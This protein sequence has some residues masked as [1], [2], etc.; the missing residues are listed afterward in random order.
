MAAQAA[1]LPAVVSV[2]AVAVANCLVVAAA[3]AARVVVAHVAAPLA[4]FESL[5]KAAT[6]SWLFSAGPV[7]RAA[8]Q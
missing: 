8:L 2:L 5:P 3:A 4:E 1:D 7:A 6:G